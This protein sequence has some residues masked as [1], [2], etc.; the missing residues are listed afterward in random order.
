MTELLEE[1]FDKVSTLPETLQDEIAKELLADIDSDSRW[2]KISEHLKTLV[3]NGQI[4]DARKVLLTVQPGVS[5]ELDH[6][7]ETLAIPKATVSNSATGGNIKDDILWIQ[8]NSEKYKGKWIALKN[9]QLLGADE[10]RIELH[11]SLKQASNLAGATFFRI[12]N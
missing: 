12:D 6:W 9:G 2:R 10:S 11:Q 3:E 7:L 5:E 1:A 4:E 8:H